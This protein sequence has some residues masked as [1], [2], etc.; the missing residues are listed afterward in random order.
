M[1]KILKT[2]ESLSPYAKLKMA[3]K[4]YNIQKINKSNLNFKNINYHNIS[5]YKHL[6]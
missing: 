5:F 4:V 1:L 6:S 2:N 3:N